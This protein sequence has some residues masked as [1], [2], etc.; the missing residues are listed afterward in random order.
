M[1]GAYKKNKLV[2]L[3]KTKQLQLPIFLTNNGKLKLRLKTLDTSSDAILFIVKS[4]SMHSVCISYK[5][6]IRCENKVNNVLYFITV[7]KA[8]YRLNS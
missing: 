6:K 1:P 8:L 7:Y 4:S 3:V 5:G 2:I